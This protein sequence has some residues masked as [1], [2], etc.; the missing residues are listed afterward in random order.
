MPI[1]QW[2]AIKEEAVDPGFCSAR[3]AIV[4][5]REIEV[6]RLIFPAGTEIKPHAIPNEQILVIMGGRARFRI[7]DQERLAGPGEALLIRPETVFSA[8]ILAEP[9]EV[10]R[11]E[12]RGSAGPA[13]GRGGAGPAF[14]KWEEMASDFI[15]PRY[16]SGQGPTI[17]GERIEVAYMTYPAGT[18]GKPHVHPNEQIQ[19]PLKGR[20]RYLLE[21]PQEAGPGEVVLIPADLRHGAQILEDF[22]VLNCKNIVAGWSVYNAG[23]EK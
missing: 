23:W 1:I 7:G 14:F 13:T 17:T 9:F 2:P 11:F 18:E 10:Y 5:G 12:D 16:S 19:V 15:T 22:T 4:R 8:G 21:E 3:G 6:G 20:V